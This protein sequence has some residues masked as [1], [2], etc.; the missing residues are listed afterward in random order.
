VDRKTKVRLLAAATV[1]V[2]ALLG[3]AAASPAADIGANDNTG[4]YEPNGGAQFYETMASLGLKRIVVTVHFHPR[5]PMEIENK[6]LLDQTIPAALAAGLEVVIA[7]YP[8]P[9]QELAAGHGSASLFGS[10]AATLAEIYP[11]VKEFAVGNEPNQPV[12]WRPQF[13]SGGHNVSAAAFGQYLATAYDS[14]KAVDPKIN[15]VGVGLS[16]R[17]NDNPTAKDNISTSPVRFLRALGR[18]YRASGRGKP[19]MDAFGFHPYPHKATDTLD[20][21]YAWPNAGFVN[22]DRIKQALWDAFHGT[23][24][25]TTLDGLKI[26]LDEVGWQVDTSG[27]PGYMGAENVP[28]TTEAKQAAIYG[29][30]IRRAACDPDVTEVNFFGFRDDASLKGFQSALERLDG[31]LRPA[32]AAGAAAAAETPSGCHRRIVRWQPRSAVLDPLV[33]AHSAPRASV[34]VRI[35]AGEDAGALVCVSRA[36]RSSRFRAPAA[37]RVRGAA[38]RT[39]LVK[40]LRPLSLGL[41]TPADAR[42]KVEVAVQLTAA[43]NRARRTTVVRTLP[44][45]G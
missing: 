14:L 18:W 7:V 4:L 27:L 34:A 41:K 33:A 13:G 42:K 15:V 8:F 19:L 9:P 30:L 35:G 12:F 43:A 21:G 3:S 20:R 31:S 44:L 40:G 26:H 11:E 24:Q 1:L 25:P 2:T 16:P 28:V 22:L 5:A 6:A 45:R 32:A 29:E 38:C 37:L 10:F 39:A 23:A 17:G 36:T